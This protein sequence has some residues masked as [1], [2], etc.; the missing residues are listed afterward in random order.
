MENQCSKEIKIIRRESVFPISTKIRHLVRE[1]KPVIKADLAK[2]VAHKCTKLLR[3]EVRIPKT[4]A[5]LSK[6]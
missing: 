6:H 3:G 2:R 5:L 4:E 1:T